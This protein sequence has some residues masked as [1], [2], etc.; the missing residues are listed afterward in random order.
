MMRPT[1][2]EF[3][4]R[5]FHGA[6]AVLRITL[7]L[8]P[9]TVLRIAS[10]VTVFALCLLLS[11]ITWRRSSILGF[12]V[13]L[14]LFAV[15]VTPLQAWSLVQGLSA[16]VGLLGVLLT[17]WA[18]DRDSPWSVAISASSGVV[19][20]GISYLFAPMVY[21]ILLASLIIGI[22]ISNPTRSPY[23]ARQV[24]MTSVAW[25][26][27]YGFTMASRFAWN[28]VALGRDPSLAEAHWAV[29][30][31]STSGVLQP[32]TN[33]GVSAKSFLGFP[34][35]ATA[36]TGLLILL[37]SAILLS[38]KGHLVGL[39][40]FLFATPALMGIAWL[41][42]FGGHNFHPWVI[43]VP[44]A[45]VLLT[46]AV[47]LHEDLIWGAARDV[48]IAYLVFA[49]VLGFLFASVALRT[50]QAPEIYVRATWSLVAAATAMGA[51]WTMIMFVDG[52]HEW[53]LPTRYLVP[54]MPAIVITVLPVL[55]RH[56]RANRLGIG[57]GFISAAL[58]SSRWEQVL[59]VPTAL[60]DRL[61]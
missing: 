15:T 49:L 57:A 60:I 8:A 21:P 6:S 50:V 14:Y 61:S 27:G 40:V 31:R 53:V 36:T 30:S 25:V 45:M 42:A 39:E 18:V 13:T 35:Q 58:L 20:A 34:I 44:L 22:A 55:E 1:G 19:Y 38:R 4:S 32:I 29:I 47:F 56:R 9:I 17:L 12:G 43:Q 33:L 2:E 5:Y 24:A 51:A 16:V 37:L 3:Y 41:A 10:V 11:I 48:S 46:V 52:G 7:P 26:L 28:F 54:L 59:V 23:V